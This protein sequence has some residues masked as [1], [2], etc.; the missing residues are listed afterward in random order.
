MNNKL[1]Y[2]WMIN[3]VIIKGRVS[4]PIIEWGIGE[5]KFSLE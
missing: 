5:K 1:E 3:L 2:K 4:N